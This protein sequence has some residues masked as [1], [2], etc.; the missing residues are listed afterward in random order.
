MGYIQQATEG[1]DGGA[2]ARRARVAAARLRGETGREI[3][4]REGVGEA[5]V[6]RDWAAARAEWRR[7]REDAAELLDMEYGRLLYQEHLAAAA[8]EREPTAAWM[9][10][11]LRVGIER[12]RLLGLDAPPATPRFRPRV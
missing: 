10:V 7:Q 11:W 9:A 1:A 5:T 12:R 8:Y 2:D 4:E 3:A 6:W